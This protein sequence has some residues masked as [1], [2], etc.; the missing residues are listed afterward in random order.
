MTSRPKVVITHR[1]HQPVKDLLSAQCEVIAN[2]DVETWPRTRLLQFSRDAAGLLVFMPDLIDDALLAACPDLRVIAAALKGFDNIDVA[3]CTRRGIWVAIVPDLLTSPTA[4]LALTLT[5]GLTRN[6]LPGDGRVR[7]GEFHGWRPL[8]YGDG[9]VGKT[10]GVVGMG[11]LGQAF[12]KL[13]SGFNVRV[14]YY[15]P[16]PL[17]PVQ[18][19]FLGV[20]RRTLDQLLSQSDITVL[21]APLTPASLHLIKEDSLRQM[22]PG[23]YLVN[24]GRGSVVDEQAVANALQ[25]GRLA[26]YAADVFEMEDWA[27]SDHPASVAPAL[28]AQADKTLF[29]PHLGSAVKA[30]RLEIEMAAARSILQVLRGE[31]PQGA[32]NEP[33]SP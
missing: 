32:I 26:G 29:T 12:V 30:V 7:A 14:L 27:R 18:D 15:D 8:L 6:V 17:S 1:V 16:V 20:A 22:K 9:L 11:K 3:A 19:A 5:L 23:S 25:E 28:A 33:P 21:L 4:E 24:V 13:L 2:D 10:V 31:R